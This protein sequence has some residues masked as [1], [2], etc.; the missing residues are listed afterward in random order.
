MLPCTQISKQSFLH[1]LC[2][3]WQCISELE[4]CY[5][6]TSWIPVHR[7]LV[8]YRR[9]LF[10][11]YQAFTLT[12]QK[13]VSPKRLFFSSLTYNCYG[14]ISV[15]SMWGNPCMLLLRVPWCETTPVRRKTQRRH[16][17]LS[18]SLCQGHPKSRRNDGTAISKYIR[19]GSRRNSNKL[20]RTTERPTIRANQCSAFN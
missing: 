10:F 9:D 17:V 12:Y 13:S 1:Q 15:P 18:Q 6:R 7:T 19:Q 8:G 11:N 14:L 2:L 3:T 4:D 16:C 5:T 20:D